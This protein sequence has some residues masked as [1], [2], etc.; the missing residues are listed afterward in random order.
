MFFLLIFL[1]KSLVTHLNS[2]W[3]P[4]TQHRLHSKVI[5][6][7]VIILTRSLVMRAWGACGATVNFVKLTLSHK[8][9]YMQD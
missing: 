5:V 6:L 8:T 4:V 2:Q 1:L 9:Q 3:L 7:L